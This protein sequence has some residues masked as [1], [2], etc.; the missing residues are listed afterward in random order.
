MVISALQRQFP[1]SLKRALQDAIML[2]VNNRKRGV[3]VVSI[4][5]I[6]Y[7]LTHEL[8]HAV[9]GHVDFF[10]GTDWKAALPEESALVH[11]SRVEDFVKIRE[12]EAD[13]AALNILYRL[14]PLFQ[15]HVGI[16]NENH[17]L[18]GVS[19]RAL[20]SMRQILLF[21]AIIGTFRFDNHSMDTGK[22]MYGSFSRSRIVGIIIYFILVAKRGS[23]ILD[24]ATRTISC[25]DGK[26]PNVLRHFIT[27]VL[28][29]LEWGQRAAD[30][31]GFEINLTEPRGIGTSEHPI[32]LDILAMVAGGRAFSGSALA[33]R[34]LGPSLGL[35]YDQ[36]RN[37]RKGKPL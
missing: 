17:H 11:A 13:G 4:L 37:R 14:L 8:A 5:C 32:A 35:W 6:S 21:A 30:A 27:D 18:T 16:G 20:K 33:I 12:L 34:N 10:Q 19:R 31:A 7:L 15:A 26:L 36:I 23:V 3:D 2:A 29:V 1:V 24:E 28:P 9:A 25:K 22:P